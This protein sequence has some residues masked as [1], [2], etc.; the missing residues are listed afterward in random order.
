[1]RFCNQMLKYFSFLEIA[2]LFKVCF[3]WFWSIY[4]TL[5]V[6]VVAC[7][8]CSGVFSHTLSF[9]SQLFYYSFH[10]F[11]PFLLLDGFPDL[12]FWVTDAFLASPTL[13]FIAVPFVLKLRT[14]QGTFPLGRAGSP[15]HL[16]LPGTRLIRAFLTLS[17]FFLLVQDRV[18]YFAFSTSRLFPFL[19][20]WMFSSI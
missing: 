4:Y 7:P 8:L 15:L 9:T 1:M 19:S 20:C 10:L 18:F 2:S 5:H 12:S 17:P 6:Y 16:T 3:F 14:L 11:Y 13:C